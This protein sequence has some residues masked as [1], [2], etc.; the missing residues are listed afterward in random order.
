MTI[1]LAVLILFFVLFVTAC[2]CNNHS[3]S[4]SYNETKEYGVCKCDLCKDSFYRNAT[5]PQKDSNICLGKSDHCSDEP[6][7]VEL[8]ST[9]SAKK[10]I[11]Q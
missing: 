7:F 8:Q 2:E 9:Q 3:D 11:F 6:N 5:V 4:C 1:V 10:T